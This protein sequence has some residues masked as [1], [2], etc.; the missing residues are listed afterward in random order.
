MSPVLTKICLKLRK[1]VLSNH[2]I[3]LFCVK[4]CKCEYIVNIFIIKT[5]QSRLLT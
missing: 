5:I 4:Y 2:I 3:T 1:L